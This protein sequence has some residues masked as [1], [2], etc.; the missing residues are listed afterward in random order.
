MSLGDC[1]LIL[2]EKNSCLVS[3]K[4]EQGQM[5]ASESLSP[6]LGLRPLTL[7]T[8]S[9]LPRATWAATKASELE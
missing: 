5:Q 2:G 7:L 3:A 6:K 8:K 4:L 9:L 1:D